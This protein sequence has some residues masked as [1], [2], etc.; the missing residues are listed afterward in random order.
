VAEALVRW[1][2][3]ILSFTAQE[4]WG[5]LPGQR[6]PFVFT[7][8]WY[9]FPAHGKAAMIDWDRLLAARAAVG[10]ILERMRKDGR[11]GSSLG[12]ELTLFAEP[13]LLETMQQLGEELRFVFIT[14]EA[15]CVPAVDRGADAE[16]TELAELWVSARP[17][18]HAKCVRCWH[19]RADVG[20]DPE[21]PELCGRCITNVTGAGETRRFA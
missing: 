6:D 19:H 7:Q 1:L 8:T 2:A 11:I 21:H 16:P 18:E 17:T 12:A 15:A 5:H 14:S 3:P 20:A 9:Q 10:P 13:A 4:I